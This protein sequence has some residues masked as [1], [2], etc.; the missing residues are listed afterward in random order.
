[1]LLHM[2]LLFYALTEQSAGSDFSL[3]GLFLLLF[4]KEQAGCQSPHKVSKYDATAHLPNSITAVNTLPLTS[5]NRLLQTCRSH[6]RSVQVNS[7]KSKNKCFLTYSPLIFLTM[8]PSECSK[9]IP[10]TS[11]CLPHC[12]FS[13]FLVVL[14]K[15]LPLQYQ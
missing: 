4:G 13:V 3:S 2:I 1:M 11:Y 15:N 7:L 12:F 6:C 14:I 8:Q 9:S 5:F 10:P